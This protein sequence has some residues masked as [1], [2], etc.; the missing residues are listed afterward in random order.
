MGDFLNRIDPRTV[1]ST[2]K[3]WQEAVS[4]ARNNLQ[5]IPPSIGDKL[6]VSNNMLN[7]LTDND[8]LVITKIGISLSTNS[9][10]ELFMCDHWEVFHNNLLLSETSVVSGENKLVN[11]RNLYANKESYQKGVLQSKNILSKPPPPNFIEKWPIIG[12][13]EF[14]QRMSK[15]D[16]EALIATRITLLLGKGQEITEIYQTDDWEL[17][18]HN[19]AVIKK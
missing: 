17:L 8:A 9:K 13:E 3:S 18:I 16:N 1:Y 4:I 12:H 15:S 10:L 6:M 7:N 2:E 11:I 5:N 19:L 14:R